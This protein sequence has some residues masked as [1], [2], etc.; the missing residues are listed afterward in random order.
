MIKIFLLWIIA[1]IAIYL[2]LVI[3]N[4]V[5][6]TFILFYGA[7]C[8]LKPIIDL[9]IIN[10]KNYKEY[11]LYLGFKNSKNTIIPSSITGI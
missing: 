9:M 1:L 4:N 6:L 3:F 2:G 11:L 8:L 10:K 5:V 7:I